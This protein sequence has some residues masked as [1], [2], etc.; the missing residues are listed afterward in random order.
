VGDGFGEGLAL[1]DG[2]ALGGRVVLL[3]LGL[4]GVGA[5]AADTVADAREVAASEGEL[6]GTSGHGGA[7]RAPVGKRLGGALLT[8][9]VALGTACAV[10][11]TFACSAGPGNPASAGLPGFG[12]VA[13]KLMVAP[14]RPSD[15]ASIVTAI[16]AR[17]PPLRRS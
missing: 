8:R 11:G 9:P 6:A 2:E 16:A 14:I 7:V 3:A 12:S 4:D 5:G 1:A 17:A 10:S 13:P 15:T